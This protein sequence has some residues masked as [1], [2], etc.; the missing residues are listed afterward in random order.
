MNYPKKPGVNAVSIAA[1]C[2]YNIQSESL[3]F[4]NLSVLL[5]N[6]DIFKVTLTQKTKI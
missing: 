6:H 2:L 3:V 5:Q 4:K 1:L